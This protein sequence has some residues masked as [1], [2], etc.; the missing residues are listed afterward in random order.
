MPQ[1]L[2]DYQQ[3]QHQ[4][5]GIA[6]RLGIAGLYFFA[7]GAWLHKGV[8]IA[9]L[10]MMLF[11]A[12]LDRKE[13]WRTVR[14]S[15]LVWVTLA[16]GL[17]VLTRTM[18]SSVTD[19]ANSALHLKD[20]LRFFYLC[21]FL[22]TAWYLAASQK[23]MLTVFAIAFAGFLFARFWY[24]D[25]SFSSTIPWWK[26]RQG[27]G[28]PEI[29]FGYYAATA[30]LGLVIFT[31]R[32]YGSLR[33]GYTRMAFSLIWVLLIALSVQGIVFSQSRAVWASLL[34]ISPIL[35]FAFWKK[36][37]TLKKPAN[38]TILFALIF[39]A[40][41]TTTAVLFQ[42]NRDVLIQR[43]TLEK[44]TYTQLLSGDFDAITSSNELGQGNSVGARL[45]LLKTGIEHWIE[46]PIIG[47]G[48]AASKIILGK[49]DDV[50]LVQLNDWHNGPI[51]ILVRYGIIGL[52]L[53]TVCLWLTLSAGWRA[54]RKKRIDRDLFLF[55]AGGTALILLS[56]LT[57][58][59][60][61]NNDWRYWIFL[62]SGAFASFELHQRTRIDPAV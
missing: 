38:Q 14:R 56:M 46:S 40:L 26:L 7:F 53:M 41:I 59:R 22:L 36:I 6:E 30:L 19:S 50:I 54:Y 48:P 34:A 37:K 35:L 13:I 2:Y 32:I 21:G 61:L 15:P 33:S 55:L 49:S 20:G 62:F 44:E 1:A 23:R 29:A 42:L 25:W 9:G 39:L 8:A 11:A 27:L 43:I 47:K 45:L 16:T 5:A 52:L 58:F 28:L 31:P 18:L 17:Y 10:G 4:V 12:L 60:M 24:F 57:N 51:D 3:T